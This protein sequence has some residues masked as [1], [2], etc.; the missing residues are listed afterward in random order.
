M[1]NLFLIRYGEIG[2]KGH[3]RYKFENQLMTNIKT[4]LQS[5]GAEPKVTK[6]FGRIFV[7]TNFDQLDVVERL[8]K[9]FGIVGIC[10]AKK[11]DLDFD[12]IKEKALELIRAKIEKN[13]QLIPFRVT[14]KRANKSFPLDTMEINQQLGFYLLKNTPDGS[15]KVNLNE[16]E[17]DLTVEIRENN[18][19]VY[20]TEEAGSGGLPV[21]IS[22]KAGLM[23]SG[24]I[25][26]PVAGW[27]A[28]KRGVEIMPIYFHT[29]PF[30]S[31]RA[32]EKVIDLAKEL[33]PYQ[34]GGLELEIV[35][36]TKIQTEINQNCPEDLITLIMRRQMIKVAQK[37]M[38]RKQGKAL[39]TGES[40]AQVASQTL[41]SMQVTNH[42]SDLPIF[43]P[44]IGFDKTEIINK[45]RKIGTY[46]LSTK[47]AQDCCTVF[48]PNTPETHPNLCQIEEGEEELVIDELITEAV[49]NTEVIFL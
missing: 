18:A 33:A 2:T 10:P 15:L 19:Y 17:I 40:I 27:L 1:K 9:V 26:S 43:R 34:P 20:A 3:N 46:Q 42:I 11:V 38:N 4:A 6:T 30:T 48:V 22:D 14:T 47:P 39:I 37:I 12:E 23:L 25:D 36:F 32:K 21:G 31:E 5:L 44:L 13:N 7:E 35:D 28:M 41:D 16:A 24:G 45:A 49:N 29:P 8:A